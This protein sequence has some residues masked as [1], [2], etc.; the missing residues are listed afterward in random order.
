VVSS[1]VSLAVPYYMGK[2]ID[3][4]NESAHD[5]T[6]MTKMTSICSYLLVVFVVGALANFG[7]S[8]L[9][10]ISCN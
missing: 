8:Y 1:S 6:L 7:R 4:I 10:E 9:M 5:G 3:I 2:I